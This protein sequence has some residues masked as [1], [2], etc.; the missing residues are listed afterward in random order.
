M[1]LWR[2][3][4][5]LRVRGWL[6]VNLMKLRGQQTRWYQRLCHH[7]RFHRRSQPAITTSPIP[8]SSSRQ[9]GGTTRWWCWWWFFDPVSTQS[10]YGG[11][12]IVAWGMDLEVRKR[13]I[14]DFV[15]F[16]FCY[17]RYWNCGPLLQRAPIGK[18]TTECAS[19]RTH[20]G[21][22]Q[23]EYSAVLWRKKGRENSIIHIINYSYLRNYFVVGTVYLPRYFHIWATCITR[24]VSIRHHVRPL[25]S[26]ICKDLNTFR[27]R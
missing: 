8:T 26:G 2:L 17:T 1:D 15:R 27:L 10:W 9:R 3:W 19:I 16:V 23:L 13:E 5:H 18:Y 21:V 20:Y 6:S 11:P 22:L 25:T 24:I 4:T 7:G 14:I 12:S